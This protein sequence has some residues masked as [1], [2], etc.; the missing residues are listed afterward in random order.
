MR[1]RMLTTNYKQSFI[2]DHCKESYCNPCGFSSRP[3][4]TSRASSTIIARRATAIP[5]VFPLALV[6]GVTKD[7]LPNQ[8][9][10]PNIYCTMLALEFHSAN[11]YP[12]NI[13]I[14]VCRSV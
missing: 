7:G 13:F 9:E 11:S 5:A 1:I 3:Q 8:P 14:C 2:N 12:H 4:I 10:S 6:L